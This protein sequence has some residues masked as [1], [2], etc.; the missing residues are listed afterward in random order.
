MQMK[1]VPPTRLVIL[2]ADTTVVGRP[3]KKT[4]IIAEDASNR[5]IKMAVIKKMAPV[6]LD[7][8]RYVFVFLLRFF[9]LLFYYF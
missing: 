3:E 5:G 6:G 1:S 8:I 4:I 7:E 9:L 2:P